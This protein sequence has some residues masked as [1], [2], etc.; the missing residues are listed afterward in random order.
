[1]SQS[2]I[3]SSTGSSPPSPTVFATNSG[4]ASAIGDVLNL[5]GV[6]AVTTQ[7]ATN[8]VLIGLTA[9]ISVATGGTGRTTLTSHAVLVGAATS[10]V[11]QL[12]VGN[13]NSVLTGTTSADP[14]FSTTSTS[15]FSGVSFNAG[16]DILTNYSVGSFVPTVVGGTVPGTTAYADQHG[17]YTRIGNIC[18]VSIYVLVNSVTGTGQATFNNLPFTVKNQTSYDPIAPTVVLGAPLTTGNT[19]LWAQAV[20]NTTTAVVFQ[21]NP[22]TGMSVSFDISAPAQTS[23]YLSLIYQI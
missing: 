10:G 9:P 17:Y 3:I 12:T 5:I 15:Y 20:S 21:M 14:V 23:Y 22:V 6:G 13:T 2:G 8:N 7:G 11:T 19:A 4:N 16:T 18:C 1:M